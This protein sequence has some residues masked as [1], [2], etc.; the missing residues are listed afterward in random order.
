MSAINRELQ[1]NLKPSTVKAKRYT[2][3]I[4]SLAQNT[5]YNPSDTIIFQLPVGTNATYLDGKTAFL[6]FTVTFTWTASG[7][8]QVSGAPVSLDYSASCFFQQLTTYGNSGQLLEQI[9]RYNVLNNTLLDVF[10]C[11]SELKGLSAMIGTG[12]S[13]TVAG[14]ATLVTG[15]YD[16]DS[17]RYGKTFYNDVF[18]GAGTNVKSYT[19]CIPIMSGL[20]QLSEKYLPLHAIS[21]DSIRL[22]FQLDTN[23]NAVRYDTTTANL[24][25][26]GWVVSNPEIIVDFVEVSPD[27]MIGIEELYKGRDLVLHASAYRCYEA[28]LST[29]TSGQY[30]LILPSKLASVKNLIQ[31]HRSTAVQAQRGYTLANFSNVLYGA[32]S[33]WNLSLSGRRLPAKPMMT[34]IDGDVSQ[35][36][37]ELQK[38]YHA[39]AYTSY[40]TCLSYSAYQSGTNSGVGTTPNQTA[41]IIGLNLSSIQNSDDSIMSGVDLS[42]EQTYIEYN[43]TT[44]LTQNMTV[45]TFLLHDILY[46]VD[47]NGILTAKF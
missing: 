40:N 6:K 33:S 34:R 32:S 39:L 47:A 14:G 10:Y 1:F 44:A 28:T 4:Y 16:Y 9:S 2:K 37:S 43:I 11:Q 27:A 3:N 41:F 30:S 36:W 7:A 20:F 31:V 13:T 12:E 45:D 17:L 25:S 24:T 29:G 18:A 42:K 23:A 19:F 38:A 22:E 21:G 8:I 5:S 46:V 26:I 35:Y 15:Q